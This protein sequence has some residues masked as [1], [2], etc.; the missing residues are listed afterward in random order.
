MSRLLKGCALGCGGLVLI[1]A[2]G[3][4]GT[5]LWVKNTFKPKPADP[6]IGKRVAHRPVFVMANQ[7][8]FSAGTAWAG[9]T[10]VGAQ[11][12]LFTALHLFGPDGGLDKQIVPA[13]M[14]QSVRSVL[15]LPFGVRRPSTVADKPLLR[16]GQPMGEGEGLD[17]SGDIA[18]FRLPPKAPVN[19]LTLAQKDAGMGEWVWLVGD[20]V[21]HQPEQQRLWPA[22]VIMNSPKALM[23]RFE[24]PVR[25]QAFS[26]A[27]VINAKSEVV[28]MLIGGTP[29]GGGIVNPVSS[30]R[31]RLAESG[32][33]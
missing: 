8:S 32:V 4:G 13:K 6:K 24:K 27:P 15:L 31:K 30:M 21:D 19:A 7:K 10:R 11:P 26:G 23:M 20:E 25:L 33:Q 16:T 5:A 22:Q 14:G 28:G 29:N 1:T 12:H 17:A 18:V 9:R 3:I 2:L